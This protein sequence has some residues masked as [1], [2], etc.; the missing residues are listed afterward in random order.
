MPKLKPGTRIPTPQEDAEIN[1][2]VAGDPDTRPLT[3][4]W[5]KSARPASTTLAPAA[6]ESLLTVKKKRGRPPSEPGK[7]FI[8]LRV[9]TDVVEAFKATGKGWQT[10]MNL[11]LRCYLKTPAMQEMT[12]ASPETGGRKRSLPPKRQ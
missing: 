6:Y 5:F 1:R 7:C 8:G 4:A 3:K 10:R 9:D 11:A 2:A 12:T